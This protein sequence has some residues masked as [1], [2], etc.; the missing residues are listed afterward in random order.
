MK[1]RDTPLL[2]LFQ[3]AAGTASIISLCLFF[4]AGSPTA[5]IAALV[6]VIAFMMAV[7]YRFY[8]ITNDILTKRYPTGT[9]T[10]ST[11]AVYRTEDGQHY[12]LN[13]FK[14]I[15]CKTPYMN[16]YDY[17]FNWTG[18][19]Y[20]EIESELQQIGPITKTPDGQYD[21]V[22]L[23]FV[24]PILYNQNEV[25]HIRMNLNDA[26]GTSSPHLESRVEEPVRIIHWRVELR[27]L[28]GN[29]HLPAKIYKKRINAEVSQSYIHIDTVPFDTM[30]KSYNHYL[31]NPEIGYY[32]RIEWEK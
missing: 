2:Q 18:S 32:Y 13:I 11:F 19:N 8:Q 4:V 14:N 23:G 26:D 15:Q 16:S 22:R 25:I 12:I 21:T 30:S 3:I 1:L 6:S 9:F 24:K 10:S 17:G 29:E 7:F 31:M 28:E 20:P 27:H 5:I